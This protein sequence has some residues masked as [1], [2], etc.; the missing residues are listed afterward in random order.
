MAA[1]LSFVSVSFFSF[2]MATSRAKMWEEEPSANKSAPP[3]V[4]LGIGSPFGLAI[5]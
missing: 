4:C 3:L 1:S 2:A 5:V